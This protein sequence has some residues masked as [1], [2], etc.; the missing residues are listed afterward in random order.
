MA[1]AP[2]P[3]M[4]PLT[5]ASVADAGPVPSLAQYVSRILPSDPGHPFP[6]R[7]RTEIGLLTK[8]ADD[9]DRAC[10]LFVNNFWQSYLHSSAFRTDI[11]KYGLSISPQIRASAL[12]VPGSFPRYDLLLFHPD[13]PEAEIGFLVSP[14][15]DDL[16]DGWFAATADRVDRLRGYSGVWWSNPIDLQERYHLTPTLAYTASKTIKSGMVVTKPFREELTMIPLPALKIEPRLG[17]PFSSA[18]VFARDAKGRTGVTGA[19]H[20]IEKRSHPYGGGRK[21]RVISHDEQFTDSCFIEVAD[22]DMR[23]LRPS[24]ILRL[25]PRQHELASFQRLESPQRN[26]CRIVAWSYELPYL[27]PYLQQTVR[28]D[29][30]T[31]PGD[32]GLA[33]VD[34]TNQLMAFA[35]ARSAASA[36][37]SYSSWIWADSV[38]HRHQLTLI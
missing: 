4:P 19:A 3:I 29:I 16:I 10:S 15:Q 37:A 24:G 8:S 9:L 32:S 12:V 34:S 35:Y 28:T 38:I 13:A 23:G 26:E 31:V 21:G 25:A 17:A 7:I 1:V 22:F 36:P 30:V 33:L 11:G 5:R 14:S 2:P 20:A 6:D 18:G 27:D